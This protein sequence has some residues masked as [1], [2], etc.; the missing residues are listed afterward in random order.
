MTD[1]TLTPATPA[2]AAIAVD[3]WWIDTDADEVEG[4]DLLRDEAL[5]DVVGVPFMGFKAIY[6]DGVQRKGAEWRDDYVS[7][8][9]RVAPLQSIMA[10]LTRIQTRRRSFNVPVLTTDQISLIAGEQLVLNDGSTGLYRQ[11]TEYLA[12]KELIKL[13]EGDEQG[14]KGD[15][16]FDLPRSQWLAGAEDATVGIDIRLRCSRGLRYS[17]YSNEFT[18]D[19]EKARTWYIA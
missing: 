14:E 18:G 2:E 10:N 17:E 15:T 4:S 3:A 1:G 5:Y 8:E 12:A 13:P 7:L 6:R 19:N 9:L 16:I 11:I